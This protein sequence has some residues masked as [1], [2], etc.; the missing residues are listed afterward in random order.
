[1]LLLDECHGNERLMLEMVRFM[2]QGYFVGVSTGCFCAI[3]TFE[4]VVTRDRIFR[5]HKQNLTV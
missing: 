4:F 3:F 2:M 1:M 5:S